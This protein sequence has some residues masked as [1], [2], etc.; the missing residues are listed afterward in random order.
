MCRPGLPLRVAS[1]P[2]LLGELL[3]GA[4]IDRIERE[5][6]ARSAPLSYVDTCARAIAC[7]ARDSAVCARSFASHRRRFNVSAMVSSSRIRSRAPSSAAWAFAGLGGPVAVEGSASVD[8]SVG[9][10]KWKSFRRSRVL[11]ASDALRGYNFARHARGWRKIGSCLARH[12]EL[13]SGLWS[14]MAKAATSLARGAAIIGAA[15]WL[16]PAAA[17]E[18]GW[19]QIKIESASPAKSVRISNRS[20]RSR[21]QAIK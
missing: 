14:H 3:T 6:G 13:M 11:V 2:S 15:C 18:P 9:G 8:C 19:H 16:T 12:D 7:S 5:S 21:F 4:G 1:G 17:R 20:S 10:K